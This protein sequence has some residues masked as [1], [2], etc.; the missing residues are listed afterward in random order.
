MELR[1]DR[2]LLRPIQA[3]DWHA[4]RAIWAALA[5][6]PS[7]Q[8]DR[9]FDLTPEH[10]RSRVSRWAAASAAG[11]E[12]LFFAVCLEGDVIGYFAF[13]RR[14]GSH[15]VG[16]SFH[17]SHHGRGYAREA[18]SALL[19]HLYGLGVT[20]FSAGTALAN[21]PSVK[22]LTGLGFRFVGTEKVSFYQDADGKDIVFDG[23]IFELG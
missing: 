11:T 12:H 1:T 8:Y 6:L 5:P 7:A 18:L 20:R 22:L 2:L 13:N 16:Y 10:V 21:T 23:G 3:E 17:P 15:E 19:S 4:I 14:E 9:P